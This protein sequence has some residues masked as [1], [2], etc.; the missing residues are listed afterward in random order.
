MRLIWYYGHFPG[1]K[2]YCFSPC[3]DLMLN[4]GIIGPQYTR[5]KDPEMCKMSC[6]S[7]SLKIFFAGTPLVDDDLLKVT[8]PP[9]L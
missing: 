6:Y 5:M 8:N 7:C 2:Y 1:N 4:E 3:Q 9:R